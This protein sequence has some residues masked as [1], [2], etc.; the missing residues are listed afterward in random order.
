MGFK[1]NQKVTNHCCNLSC[2]YSMNRSA[3]PG[4]V[5]A[6][7]LLQFELHCWLLFSLGVMQRTFQR[8]ERQPVRRKLLSWY[9][10]DFSLS[11][12]KCMMSSS[13]AGSYH[14]VLETSQEQRPLLILSWGALRTLLTNIFKKIIRTLHWGFYLMLYGIWVTH[15]NYF[16]MCICFRKLLQ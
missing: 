5:S 11:W 4:P 3:L 9:M 7:L 15:L 1:Y 8:Y 12:L 10:L 2:H 16:Y 13:A 14:R 6:V